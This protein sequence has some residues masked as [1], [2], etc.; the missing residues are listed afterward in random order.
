MTQSGA[1]GEY[2]AV[3]RSL[4]T[5]APNG[6]LTLEQ[7]AAIA[8]SGIA[9]YQSMDELCS[10]LARGS[11]LV[12][13]NAHEGVGAIALQLA[14][15]LRPAMDLWIIG[16]FPPDFA[17]G[18]SILRALGASET[19][20]GEAVSAVKSLRESSYDAVL[21]TIGGRQIYDA[22]KIV[23]HDD[24]YF[25]ECDEEGADDTHTV[26]LALTDRCP[27]FFFATV[28]TVGD[29]LSVPT[30]QAHWKQSLKAIFRRKEKVSL[31]GITC[32]IWVPEL[33]HAS[34]AAEK[35]HTLLVP[36]RT[37]RSASRTG[38]YEGD[39]RGRSAQAGRQTSLQVRGRHEGLP[40]PQRAGCHH[41]SRPG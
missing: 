1:L 6:V 41:A 36:F 33:T 4:L 28:T 26:L 11:K 24:G 7:I 34:H 23:L 9:A 10:T 25:G 35:E 8:L 40:R 39:L 16:H 29:A 15:A 17:D 5:R 19:L 30:S 13:L 37:G 38:P 18:D 20:C 2:L 31:L 3:E 21:D 14:Q 12:I 32:K 22:S 27:I